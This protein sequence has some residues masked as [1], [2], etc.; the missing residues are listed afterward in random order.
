MNTKKTVFILG[1]LILIAVVAGCALYPMLPERVASHWNAA[2]QADG[3]MSKFWGVFLFPLLMAG[4]LGIY[5]IIPAIDPMKA[6]IESFRRPYNL[7]WI[8]LFLFLLYMFGATLTW[9]LGYRFNFSVAMVPALAALWFGIGMFLGT[10]KRNWFI[11]I[12]TPWTLSSDAVWESTH[13][14]AGKVFMAGAPLMLLGLAF[15]RLML[16]FVFTPIVGAVVFALVYSYV[17]H[18]K[19]TTRR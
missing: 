17:Q 2:G 14:V 18:R 3:S 1:L 12:R 11:G 15:P 10:L 5:L 13:R 4:M 19:V 16:W 9:N 6:N 8:G 7:F